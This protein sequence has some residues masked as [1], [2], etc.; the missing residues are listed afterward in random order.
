MIILINSLFQT[1]D[2]ALTFACFRGYMAFVKIIVENTPAERQK[3]LI[4]HQRNVILIIFFAVLLLATFLQCHAF[5]Y[6]F[7]DNW[8]ALL[9]AS[10]HGH[11]E[12][13][14]YLLEKDA[15]MTVSNKVR[16]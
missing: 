7:Q 2:T 15:S 6:K 4:D 9:L 11:T 3:E 12:V 10:R 1:G 8:S 16:S 5:L 14:R 13:V